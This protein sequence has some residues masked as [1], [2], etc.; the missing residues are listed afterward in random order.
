VYKLHCR[1]VQVLVL[2][3]LLVLNTKAKATL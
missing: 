1:S 2:F 3:G